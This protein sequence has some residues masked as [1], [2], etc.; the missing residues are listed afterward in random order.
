MTRFYEN[1]DTHYDIYNNSMT[2]FDTYDRFYYNYD[3]Y[4]MLE[5]KIDPRGSRRCVWVP[6]NI[7]ERFQDEFHE[8]IKQSQ[9]KCPLD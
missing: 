9:D 2:P 8:G 6:I 7:H 4:D 3:I 1:Y 5:L